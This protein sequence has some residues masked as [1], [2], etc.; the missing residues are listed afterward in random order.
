MEID[1]I[2]SE[3]EQI[4][5]KYAKTCLL[6]GEAESRAEKELKKKSILKEEKHILFEQVL[7]LE[8]KV[9]LLM[10]L[11]K[12]DSPCFREAHQAPNEDLLYSL[13]SELDELNTVESEIGIEH[14]PHV[15]IVPKL[16]RNKPCEEF[17]K[18]VRYI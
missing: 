10:M 5:N 2:R 1:R 13:Q 14:L 16:S 11:E 4:S 17:F 7:M 3:K 15:E 6:L 18:L 12:A 8:Q 9:H